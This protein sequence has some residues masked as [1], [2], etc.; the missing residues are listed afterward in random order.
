MLLATKAAEHTQ[1]KGSALVAKAA[2]HTQGKGSALV[3][4][5]VETQGEGGVFSREGKTHKAK[6]VLLAAKAAETQGEGSVLPASLL[7]EMPA[8]IPV[9]DDGGVVREALREK[10]P[11]CR[12]W[13]RKGKAVGIGAV[14]GHLTLQLPKPLGETSSKHGGALGTERFSAPALRRCGEPGRC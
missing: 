12:R 11:C 1:G 5:A 2:E 6:A 4:K 7:A 13:K 9:E 14:V 10:G 3:A 8:V